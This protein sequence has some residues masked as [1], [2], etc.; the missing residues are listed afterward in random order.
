MS[1][2]IEAGKRRT[3]RKSSFSGGGS[4]NCVEIGFAGDVA[5]RDT[6]NRDGGTLEFTA[7]DWSAFAAG[8]KANRF[9]R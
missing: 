6:K 9:Q 4:G 7:A 3:W 5:V 1:D 2:L 8:V